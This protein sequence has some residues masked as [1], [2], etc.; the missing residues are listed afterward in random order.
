[1]QQTDINTTKMDDVVQ[2]CYYYSPYGNNQPH[3]SVD[4]EQQVRQE[5]QTL[6]EKHHGG[7][8]E[9]KL[10]VNMKLIQQYKACDRACDPE[11][12]DL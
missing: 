4:Q 3:H 1:M 11:S 6:S 2:S 9:K 12:A 10:S 5:E 7:D 8:C